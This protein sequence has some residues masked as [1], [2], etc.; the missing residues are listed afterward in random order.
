ML[1]NLRKVTT[2]FLAVSLVA[3]VFAQADDVTANSHPLFNGDI[4]KE[5]PDYNPGY[6]VGLHNL[7]SSIKSKY[8]ENGEYYYNKYGV[9]SFGLREPL[10]V[11]FEMITCGPGER[12]FQHV[13][14]DMIL[15]SQAEGDSFSKECIG[16]SCIERFGVLDDATSMPMAPQTFQNIVT[17]ILTGTNAT[18]NARGRLCYDMDNQSGAMNYRDPQAAE[19]TYCER[20]QLLPE[21]F[22]PIS[23]LSCRLGLDIPLKV[24][25]TR[26]VRQIQTGVPTIG[27]GFIG[28]YTDPSTG[29]AI[30]ELVS[31]PSTCDSNRADCVRTCDWAEEVVCESVDMPRWGGSD[32]QR[33]GALATTIFKGD[34]ITVSASAQL[35]Y[36]ESEGVVYEGSAIMSCAIVSGEAEWIISGQSCAPQ[37]S[38]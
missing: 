11:E 19:E 20:G 15:A 13:V 38:N 12:S 6:F 26:F 32:G 33:C 10:N 3:P 27:Q 14:A 2:L 4:V 37:S 34:A 7:N 17:D 18:N 29:N 35:S 30:A 9:N 24:G 21:Y 16:E 5:D 25:K 23:G 28:C 36:S 8:E 1:L 31:N 22:D